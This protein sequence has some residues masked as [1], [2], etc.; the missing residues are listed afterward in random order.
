VWDEEPGK[1]SRAGEIVRDV[2]GLS[3]ADAEY[4][5]AVLLAM[6]WSM[7][8]HFFSLRAAHMRH[9]WFA[10]ANADPSQAPEFLLARSLYMSERSRI[11]R[12]VQHRIPPALAEANEHE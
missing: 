10:V 5:I 2:T 12:H 11:V 4:W 8:A 1:R 6:P 9:A 7:Q 3:W